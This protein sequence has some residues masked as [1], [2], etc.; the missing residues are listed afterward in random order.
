MNFKLLCDDH[1]TLFGGKGSDTRRNLQLDWAVIRKRSFKD[2]CNLLDDLA[3]DPGIQTSRLIT[4]QTNTR[5]NELASM[6]S[7]KA[8]I[9]D[10]ADDTVSTATDT[11]GNMQEG[12]TTSRTPP[13]TPPRTLTPPRSPVPFLGLGSP[14]VQ[15]TS[16]DVA[17]DTEEHEDGTEDRPFKFFF[18]ST[19][20]HRYP[21]GFYAQIKTNKRVGSKARTVLEVCKTVACHGDD[22]HAWVVLD[23]KFAHRAIMFKGESI[24]YWMT[25]FLRLLA[26][27]TNDPNR[28]VEADAF[29]AAQAEAKA[30]NIYDFAST[31]YCMILP[32]DMYLDNYAVSND[33]SEI[34]KKLIR[35]NGKP[36][37]YKLKEVPSVVATWEV[38]LYDGKSKSVG[39]GTKKGVAD[40]F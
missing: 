31:Y 4:R 7:N 35:V 3:V 20:C 23:G 6:F 25:E 12:S 22:W 5:I 14:P 8:G 15:N 16:D 18:Y 33:E 1:P 9:L 28:K 24:D 36:P 27:D 38:A 10:G 13:R 17:I 39:G 34:E 26:S 2:Y 19:R 30:K 40:L 37:A 29:L 11:N 21:A 32:E